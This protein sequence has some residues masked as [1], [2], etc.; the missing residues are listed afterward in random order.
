MATLTPVPAL[1]PRLGWQGIR[2]LP[3]IKLPD[4]EECRRGAL[5]GNALVAP[6]AHTGAVVWTTPGYLFPGSPDLRL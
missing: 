4:L 2:P 1:W 6:P 5:Q 3:G